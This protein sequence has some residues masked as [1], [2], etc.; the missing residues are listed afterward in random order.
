MTFPATRDG[1]LLAGVLHLA[2][3]LLLLSGCLPR[4]STPPP[5]PT[6][7]PTITPRPEPTEGTSP[8]PTLLPTPQPVPPS[9]SPDQALALR[10]KFAAD[11][12]R[13]P[14]ATCYEIKLTVD[15]DT[16]TVTGH[17]RIVY[18]NTEDV[19]LDALYLRL[20]PNTPG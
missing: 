2:S 12:D 11:L 15:L 17:E 10:P 13:F 8:P 1:P 7:L 18:T 9:P 19:S 3:C 5:T 20:F 4:T 6:P 16:P 14:D